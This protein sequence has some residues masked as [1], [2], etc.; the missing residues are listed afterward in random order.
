M[1]VKDQRTVGVRS[2][3]QG[4]GPSCLYKANFKLRGELS[5]LK[6]TLVEAE[7]ISYLSQKALREPCRRSERFTAHSEETR[8]ACC[9]NNCNT[10][11]AMKGNYTNL[12][13]IPN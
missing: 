5:I 2:W 6:G 4:G 8:S 7:A 9:C 13:L 11:I 12:D 3:V 1:N 10:I